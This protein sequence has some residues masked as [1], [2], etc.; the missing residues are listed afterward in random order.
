MSVL[1]LE[2]VRYVV[3][4][5]RFNRVL[6]IPALDK[7]TQLLGSGASGSVF[8]A[9]FRSQEASGSSKESAVVAIKVS[10]KTNDTCAHEFALLHQWKAADPERW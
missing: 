4:R 10:S 2:T 6:T 8:E 3:S 1:R 7:F 9:R 5:H